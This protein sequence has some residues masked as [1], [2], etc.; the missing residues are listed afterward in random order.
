MIKIKT[1][2]A[3]QVHVPAQTAPTAADKLTYVISPEG[4]VNL[5]WGTFNVSFTVK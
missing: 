1:A 3:L 5:L 4:V 2:D